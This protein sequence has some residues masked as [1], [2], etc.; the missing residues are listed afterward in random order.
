MSM[1]RILRTLAALLL[2]AMV[3]FVAT[4]QGFAVAAAGQPSGCHHH[5]KPFPVPADHQCCRSSQQAAS[6]TAEFSFQPLSRSAKSALSL[7]SFSS[8]DNAAGSMLETASDTP[9]HLT[10]LRI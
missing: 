3:V 1:F 5:S 8:F 9:P 2:L 10:P 4:E 6:P 7:Q